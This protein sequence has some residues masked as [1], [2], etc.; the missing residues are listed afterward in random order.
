LGKKRRVQS[1]ALGFNTIYFF[2]GGLFMDKQRL[3][4]A[5]AYRKNSQLPS[6]NWYTIITDF[7]I[8][9]AI[10]IDVNENGDLLCNDGVDE[11]IIK[12]D[13]VREITLQDARNTAV[14]F[15]AIAKVFF[16]KM[17]MGGLSSIIER[18]M[19]KFKKQ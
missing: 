3:K 13:K 12:Y 6:Q 11:F 9:A 16:I 10:Y 2:E 4:E 17:G 7:E 1:S 5:V 8:K 15:N 18:E 19:D 14:A